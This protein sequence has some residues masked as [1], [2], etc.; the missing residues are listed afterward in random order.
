MS[1]TRYKKAGTEML[2][3]CWIFL[4]FLAMPVLRGVAWVLGPVFGEMPLLA[5]IAEAVYRMD[6]M[7]AL[8]WGIPLAI[9]SLI[10]RDTIIYIRRPR[11]AAEQ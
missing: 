10:V 9:V 11:G 5:E 8:A 4:M 7:D 3:L 6:A 1:T 2:F